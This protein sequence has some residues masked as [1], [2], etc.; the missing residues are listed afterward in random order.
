MNLIT[1]HL[2]AMDEG[3]PMQ[4]AEWSCNFELDT[5]HKSVSK[6]VWR[7]EMQQK[8][9]EFCSQ[10]KG[11]EPGNDVLRDKYGLPH[12]YYPPRP[13]RPEDVKWLLARR[14][15]VYR[16]QEVECALSLITYT[17][18]GLQQHMN[19]EHTKPR[20]GPVESAQQNLS[21]AVGAELHGGELTTGAATNLV[22]PSS[23]ASGPSVPYTVAQ[24]GT[25]VDIGHRSG[26]STNL[27]KRKQPQQITSRGVRDGRISRPSAINRRPLRE[28]RAKSSSKEFEG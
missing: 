2:L 27:V 15:R 16:C 19:K 21:L 12:I 13:K 22:M 1:N 23:N 14:K 6:E 7:E 24:N 20:E 28:I 11:N 5:F 26:L 4:V 17:E 18:K 9:G 3:D 10:R 8:I 25:D